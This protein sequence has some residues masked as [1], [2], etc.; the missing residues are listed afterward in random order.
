MK[1]GVPLSVAVRK[2]GI[3]RTTAYKYLDQKT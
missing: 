1:I 3:S 2:V